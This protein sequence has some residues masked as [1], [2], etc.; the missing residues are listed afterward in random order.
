MVKFLTQSIKCVIGNSL[1]HKQNC[2][3]IPAIYFNSSKM[4][5]DM[6]SCHPR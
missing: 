5:Y 4:R 3:L 6:D 2:L 1:S